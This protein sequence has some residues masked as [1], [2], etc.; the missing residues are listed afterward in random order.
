MQIGSFDERL[1]VYGWDDSD[2]Y[3]RLESHIKAKGVEVIKPYD[4][5]ARTFQRRRI[6]EHL[7]HKRS[8]DP[9]FELTG[10]CFNRA[11]LEIVPGWSSSSNS[12]EF[13]CLEEQMRQKPLYTVFACSCVREAQ[14]VQEAVNRSE[15]NR[16]AKDCVDGNS[17][18]PSFVQKICG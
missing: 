13:S 2:L 8:A 10:I 12:F 5:F 16:I 18:D 7:N 9:A 1:S 3:L 11:I 6:I 14:R 4:D 17:G 15:C